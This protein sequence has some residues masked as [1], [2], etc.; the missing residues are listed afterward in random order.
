MDKILRGLA[1]SNNVSVTLLDTTEMVQKA[2]ETHNLT[3]TP[4]AALGRTLTIATFMSACLKNKGDNLSITI[5]GD[6]LGGD[7]VVCGDKELNIKGYIENGQVEVPPNAL[8]KLDVK[9]VV[10][11]KGKITV[12]K[13]VG[14]KT[15]Y[16]GLS[17]IVSGEIAE[18]FASYYFHSEQ[19]P[20][21]IA[22]GVK[23]NTDLSC[24]SAGGVIVQPMPSCPD[25]IIDKLEALAPK[26]AKISDMIKDKG[27][28]AISS[29]YFEDFKGIALEPK[30]ECKCDREYFEKIL[31][32]L[33]KVELE[34]ILREQGK[35]EVICHF[36]N[37]K[38][39]FNEEILKLF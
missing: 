16:V 39:T 19:Q 35:I 21:L 31:V 37:K 27:L 15:P 20:T 33:G 26:F 6:G 38:Y 13:N 18:D 10:G 3:A 36:C 4:A 22:V 30:Y 29:E 34:S 7:I 8:G 12:M 1:F 32:T 17:D 11:T 23:I 9:R 25:E 28:Y 14:L 24:M 2:I 5:K